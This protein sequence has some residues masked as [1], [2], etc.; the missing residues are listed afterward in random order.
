MPDDVLSHR[1]FA[2]QLAGPISCGGLAVEVKGHDVRGERPWSLN[3]LEPV[4]AGL[5]SG[6]ICLNPE[7]WLDI[8]FQN[9]QAFLIVARSCSHG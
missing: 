3:H 9:L 1:C 2:R 8:M 6:K 4:M 5:V 7:N